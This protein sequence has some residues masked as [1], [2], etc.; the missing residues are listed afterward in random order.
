MR[1]SSLRFAAIGLLSVSLAACSSLGLGGGGDK[2]A[3]A[4]K[5]SADT[6]TD[7]SALKDR[8]ANLA[9][10]VQRA[11][12]LRGQ[13]NYDGAIHILSQLMLVAPDDPRVVGEYGK[14]LVESDRPQEAI[15]FLKRAVE[16]QPGDWTLYSALGVAYDQSSDPESAKFAY[17]R[18]LALS[19]G[20]ASVL[21]N[22]AMSR[23]IAGDVVSARRLI[24][25]ASAKNAADPKIAKNV[26]LIATYT[27]P[28]TS[29]A[30]AFARPAIALAPNG[31]GRQGTGAPRAL[32]PGSVV[33]QNVPADAHA[34]PVART[35]AGAHRAASTAGKAVQPAAVAKKKTPELRVSADAS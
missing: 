1:R 20:E 21:N 32:T 17:E 24:A 27:P 8:P 10:A 13:A 34:G 23:A 5:P 25:E 9:D 14:V 29:P 19:P 6:T 11:Q 18:A 26:A 28:P 22:F 7:I 15:D 31:P 2:A 16:L 30:P 33:I 12:T 35:R 4:A 3:S